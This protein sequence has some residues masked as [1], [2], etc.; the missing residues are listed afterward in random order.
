MSNS[1]PIESA[2]KPRRTVGMDLVYPYGVYIDG[3]EVA[4]YNSE[5]MA[6]KHFD[7]VLHGRQEQAVK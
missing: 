2:C 1:A 7:R 6:Q 3:R 4:R 5:S